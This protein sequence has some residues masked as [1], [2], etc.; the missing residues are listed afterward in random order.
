MSEIPEKYQYLI[1]DI[2]KLLEKLQNDKDFLHEF[3]ADPALATKKS[4]ASFKDIPT[5]QL[6][7]VFDEHKKRM[8]REFAA[9]TTRLQEPMASILD[10]V[11][12]LMERAFTEAIT[13]GGSHI[14]TMTNAP[15]E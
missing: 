14:Q 1:N 8:E 10:F 9:D 13:G 5:E 3:L 6:T 15:P 4:F 7:K 2:I 12:G 11:R